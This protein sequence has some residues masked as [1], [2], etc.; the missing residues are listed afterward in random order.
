MDNGDGTATLTVW[1][2]ND[3]NRA[4]A[5]GLDM[6]G[7]ELQ[8][9]NSDKSIKG[10]FLEDYSSRQPPM[11]LKLPPVQTHLRQFEKLGRWR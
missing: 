7:Y 8:V 6:R 10:I 1:D 9:T 4:R 3:G 11:S 2:N 5:F